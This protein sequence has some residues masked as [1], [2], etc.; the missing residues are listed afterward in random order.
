MKKIETTPE[1]KAMLDKAP[2]FTLEEIGVKPGKIAARGFASF[3]EY[4]NRN[5]R[6]K[7]ENPKVGISIRI[8]VSYAN[9]LRATGP[10]WQRRISDY[11]IKGIN[12]GDLGEI[13]LAETVSD[14]TAKYN[15]TKE[16]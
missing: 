3:K 16:K 11:L 13:Q 10:G 9:G 1:I 2:E 6:P 12:N 14:I 15:D 5:G 7:S 4:I 8:P